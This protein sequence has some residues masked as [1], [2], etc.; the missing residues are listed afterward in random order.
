LAIITPGLCRKSLFSRRGSRVTHQ[1]AN[2]SSSSVYYT[3]VTFGILFLFPE[4]VTS[5][6]YASRGSGRK[7]KKSKISLRVWGSVSPR[8]RARARAGV[9]LKTEKL[10]TPVTACPRLYVRLLH[11]LVNRE[12]LP[13]GNHNVN[14]IISTAVRAAPSCFFVWDVPTKRIRKRCNIFLIHYL[15]ARARARVYM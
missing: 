11:K 6:Y 2:F 7:E 15:C 13:N 12:K 10:I 9:A 5:A 8:A 3:W 1:P 14:D 4:A